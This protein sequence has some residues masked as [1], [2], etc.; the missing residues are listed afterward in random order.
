[1]RYIGNKINL[2]EFIEQ[3]LKEKAYV[4]VAVLADALELAPKMRKADREELRAADDI[5][6]LEALVTPFTIDD[7]RVYS[8]LGTGKEGLV[9]MFGVAPSD[10]D[11][12]GIAWLLAAEDLFKHNKTFIKEC[13]HWIKEMG[14]DYQYLYNFVDRRNWKVLKWLQH[15][16]FEPKQEL[17]EFGVGKLPFLLMLK[18]RETNNV[19]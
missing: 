13:P 18:E 15:L 8:I 5:S 16:G 11:T 12:Y 19:R 1:M 6:P 14:K 9:G 10:L 17:N 4:R 7:S 2:L 3:Q